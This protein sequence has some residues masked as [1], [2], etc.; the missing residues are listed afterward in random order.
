MTNSRCTKPVSL[1]RALAA[2]FLTAALGTAPMA[3]ADTV[4][5]QRVTFAKGT[6]SASLSGSVKGRD[7][8]EY[9]VGAAAGQH[10]RV[11]LA[12]PSSSIYFNVFAPGKLPGKDEALF[13][14][15]TGG[16]TFDGVLPASGDYMIQV[17]LYRNAARAG[18]TAAFSLDVAIAAQS[19]AGDDAVVPGT[20]FNA[21]GQ[22]GCARDAGQPLGQCRF[23]IIRLGNGKAEL[24]VFWPDGGSRVIYVENGQPVRYDESE[25][26]GGAK[27]S[28]SKTADL[29]TVTVGTQRFEIP[30]AAIDGG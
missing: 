23:G 19:G 9:M 15:D 16:D 12:S 26:D 22:I 11:K 29:F 28:V 27:L 17:Y 25:A 7:S 18:E 24:T 3:L 1:R 13:I 14:G 30:E 6:S 21:T 4:H 5:K 8:I 10:M 2:L 20:Q